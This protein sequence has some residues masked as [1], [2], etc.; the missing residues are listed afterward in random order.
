MRVE[1]YFGACSLSESLKWK[2]GGK[3]GCHIGGVD[4]LCPT[5]SV[6]MRGKMG[7]V[8]WAERSSEAHGRENFLLKEYA[9][10]R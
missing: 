5:G 10:R 4:K 7:Q 8:S 6:P 9:S 2:G 1:L 3:V